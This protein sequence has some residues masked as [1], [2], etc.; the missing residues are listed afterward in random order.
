MQQ[1]FYRTPK[2]HVKTIF[3]NL[4]SAADKYCLLTYPNHYNTRGYTHD[5]IE[6]RAGYARNKLIP[7]KAAV[8]A[9]P[10]N[11]E[12]YGLVDP[13]TIVKKVKKIVLSDED[14]AAKNASFILRSYLRNKVVSSY[15][16]RV[17]LLLSQI[18][19]RGGC[20]ICNAAL[21]E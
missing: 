9:I 21:Y 11:Y 2:S 12:K 20:K 3:Q 17:L 1:N 16:A 10:Q 14:V 6:V 7:S 5:T 13:K 15:R 18:H 8:Y 19:G 4:S